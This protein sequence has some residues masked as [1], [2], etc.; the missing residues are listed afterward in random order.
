M[1]AIDCLFRFFQRFRYPVSLPEEVAD[2][3]GVKLSNFITFQEFVDQLQNPTCRPTKLIKFMPREKAEEA[4]RGALRKELF[5]QNSLFSYYFSEG[6]ME[7]VLLFDEQSR[8]RRI[9]LRHKQISQEEGIEI[10]LNKE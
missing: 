10:L 5:P 8:L 2:A 7:F 4:F 6:W 3:L 1:K 9:Y